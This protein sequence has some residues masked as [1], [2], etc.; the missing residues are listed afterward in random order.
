[1]LAS[2]LPPKRLRSL[3]FE[4]PKPPNE[5]SAREAFFALQGSASG[6]GSGAGALAVFRRDAVSLPP[7]GFGIEQTTK[8]D[9]RGRAT[10]FSF[11]YSTKGKKGKL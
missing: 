5:E 3:Y 11:L 8:R 1:M 2:V 6:Y 10:T 7:I 9:R 4:V